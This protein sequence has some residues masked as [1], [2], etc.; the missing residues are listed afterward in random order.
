MHKSFTT[1]VCYYLFCIIVSFLLYGL[2]Q[3][4]SLFLACF[5][6]CLVRVVPLFDFEKQ[7]ESFTESNEGTLCFLFSDKKAINQMA[8]LIALQILLCSF[9]LFFV[10]FAF[11]YSHSGEP[12][13]F[14]EKLMA[15]YCHFDEKS[16][17]GVLLSFLVEGATFCASIASFWDLYKIPESFELL[18]VSKKK[19]Q[20]IEIK[21]KNKEKLLETL[22]H[23]YESI[24][25]EITQSFSSSNKDINEKWYQIFIFNKA[26]KVVILTDIKQYVIPFSKIID[27]S[28]SFDESHFSTIG[29]ELYQSTDSL[30]VVKRSTIGTLVGGVPG[31]VI[32]GLTAKRKSSK[33]PSFI[34]ACT[35]PMSVVSIVLDSIKLPLLH[36]DFVAD[37]DGLKT[38]SALL[39]IIIRKNASKQCTNE[40]I[41]IKDSSVYERIK[42][43][44]IDQVINNKSLIDK[45]KYKQKCGLLF[46]KSL[47]FSIFIILILLALF[48]VVNKYTEYEIRN[49]EYSEQFIGDKMIVTVDGESL[50]FVK[51]ECPDSGIWIRLGDNRLVPNTE[52][53]FYY[54]EH[55]SKIYTYYICTTE[56]TNAF[57]NAVISHDEN[58]KCPKSKGEGRLP[59]MTSKD[60]Y[61]FC[62]VSCLNKLSKKT[63]TF[64]ICSGAQWEYAYSGGQKSKKYR[65]SGSNNIDEVAWLDYTH[66]VAQK[67]TK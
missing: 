12:I 31:A 63:G 41:T 9:G 4:G 56:L 1:F 6:A 47:Y 36:I 38:F 43:K 59:F 24:Y 67:K 51:V 21:K 30:D 65:Y 32:G 45:A 3:F 10:F 7:K 60:D 46:L 48:W 14:L 34:Y 13:S 5:F 49:Y 50:E 17:L 19:E 64:M 26:E 37:K 22:K 61:V 35:A 44:K 25:G 20:L 53:D 15:N 58:Q 55:D 8:I 2:I 28:S 29:G 39:C 62:F 66:P 57:F 16:V 18:N 11:E 27:Y 52:R 54:N 42:P 33:T 23:K 40:E